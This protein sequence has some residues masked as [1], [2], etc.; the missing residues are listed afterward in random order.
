MF[1]A[2][3]AALYEEPVRVNSTILFCADDPKQAICRELLSEFNE[4][5]LLYLEAEINT[6]LKDGSTTRRL[7]RLIGALETQA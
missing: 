6:Y 3:Q 5:E 1:N 2:A 7:E 4:D